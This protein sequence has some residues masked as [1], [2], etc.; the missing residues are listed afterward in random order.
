MSDQANVNQP[1]PTAEQPKADQ[2]AASPEW[3]PS[4]N[5]VPEIYTNFVH[6]NWSLYDVRIRL[7]QLV[8]DPKS[9]NPATSKW[10]SEERAAVTFA[11]PHA[12]ILRD[13]L[14]NLVKRYE[15][16]NGEIKPLKLPPSP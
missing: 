8:P 11:W 3:V 7:G 4:P 14:I 15:E 16:V 6:A 2:V 1:N 12:K 9:T 13:L 5:G 10:V